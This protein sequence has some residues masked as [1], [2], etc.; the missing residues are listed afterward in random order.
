MIIIKIK[1]WR[2]LLHQVML[3]CGRLDLVIESSASTRLQNYTSLSEIQAD[4][5]RWE[6]VFRCGNCGGIAP[7]LP[8]GA[9][10]LAL[11]DGWHFGVFGEK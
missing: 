8:V 11:S 10:W 3:P 4:R 7:I 5:W 9:K 1:N 6:E 2:Q